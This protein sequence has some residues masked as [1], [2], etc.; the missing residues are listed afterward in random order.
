MK[1]NKSNSITGAIVL[2]L[3]G[4]FLF[5]FLI[6]LSLLSQG[7]TAVELQ[8]TF[9]EK[10]WQNYILFFLLSLPP[11]LCFERGLY[12]LRRGINIRRDEMECNKSAWRL[13]A[14]YYKYADF[15]NNIVFT[16]FF[17]II[18]ACVV[19]VLLQAELT[20]NVNTLL[21]FIGIIVYVILRKTLLAGL[22]KS[23]ARLRKGF[24]SYTLFENSIEMRLY[25]VGKSKYAVNPPAVTLLFEELDE[26]KVLNDV[27]AENYMHYTIGPDPE[28]SKTLISDKIKYLKGEIARPS[29]FRSGT[30]TNSKSVLFRGKHLFYLMTFETDD[31]E[32]IEER[33]NKR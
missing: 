6:G 8:L 22:K 30:C 32:I 28:L 2:F 14:A 21:F 7:S 33:F 10:T 15:A 4:V 5:F 25:P 20:F 13:F 11:I 12:D 17:L 27:E 1:I 24:P 18:I 19:F 26:V 16:L 3:F 9:F 29:I 23:A 31:V